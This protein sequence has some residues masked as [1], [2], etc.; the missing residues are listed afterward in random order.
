[1]VSGGIKK[2]G[3]MKS[4]SQLFWKEEIICWYL[5]RI[6]IW[7]LQMQEEIDWDSSLKAF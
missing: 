4:M 3:G 6:D 1:M 7:I 2:T 5:D